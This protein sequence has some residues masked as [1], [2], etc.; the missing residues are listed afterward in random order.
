MKPTIGL[1]RPAKTQIRVFADRMGLLQPPGYPKRDSGWM[2]RLIW[3]CWSYK[4]Y[5]S[6]C[7]ALAQIFFEE[8]LQN[9]TKAVHSKVTGYTCETSQGRQLAYSC[10]LSCTSSPFRK[11]VHWKRKDP[12]STTAEDP[13][14]LAYEVFRQFAIYLHNITTI[15]R[16]SKNINTLSKCT[17]CSNQ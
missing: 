7:H 4:S 6:F 17:A 2:Y 5:C 13:G 11:G 14:Q 3:V 9:W 10:L 8:A 12:G 15:L 16:N 1:V